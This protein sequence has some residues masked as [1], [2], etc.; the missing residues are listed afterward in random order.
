MSLHTVLNEVVTAEHILEKGL[1]RNQTNLET[2]T[3]SAVTHSGLRN[4]ARGVKI[5]VD[6]QLKEAQVLSLTSARTRT[7][8]GPAEI[9]RSSLSLTLRIPYRPRNWTM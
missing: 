5:M 1:P 9:I 7:P 3:I 6:L 4:P 8:V 2:P